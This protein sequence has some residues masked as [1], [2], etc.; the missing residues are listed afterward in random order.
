MENPT[1]AAVDAIQIRGKLQPSMV[2]ARS[3]G[4]YVPHVSASRI[5]WH[6]S[7]KANLPH[8]EHRRSPPISKQA[9]VSKG[10]R[11]RPRSSMPRCR[12]RGVAG[13]LL[14]SETMCQVLNIPDFGFCVCPGLCICSLV[15]VEP[16]YNLSALHRLIRTCPSWTASVFFTTPTRSRNRSFWFTIRK[17]FPVLPLHALDIPMRHP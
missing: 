9:S 13:N 15:R 10:L 5:P 11:G 7:S 3:T 14:S 6:N 17:P 8:R 16:T 1:S 4:T 12:C 2:N